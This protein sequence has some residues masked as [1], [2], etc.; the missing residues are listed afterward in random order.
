MDDEWPALGA[1]APRATHIRFTAND[2]DSASAP[3]PMDHD[4]PRFRDARGGARSGARGDRGVVFRHASPEEA[5]RRGVFSRR[6]HPSPPPPHQEPPPLAPSQPSAPPPRRDSYRVM[7]YN[8]LAAS[9]SRNHPELYRGVPD[10]W[11]GWPRRLRGVLAEVRALRPDVLCLQECEDFEGVRRGLAADGYEGAHAPRS[12]DKADGSSV[13]WRAEAFACE[14]TETID[15]E[16]RGLKNNAAAIARLRPRADP[17]APALVV[18]CVH[19]LFNPKRGDVK[20][21]QLRVF[22]ERA[23]AMRSGDP[24]DPSRAEVLLAG[25][26]NAEP[27]SPLYHFALTGELDV[28][29]V[30]RKAMS[31]CL[32]LASDD[33]AASIAE[34]HLMM[35]TGGFD[36]DDDEWAEWEENRRIAR[37]SSARGGGGGGGGGGVAG[38]VR[39]A[40]TRLREYFW[41]DEAIFAAFG[42]RVPGSAAAAEG[43]G[44]APARSVASRGCRVEHALRGELASCYRG[45]LGREPAATS[46]HGAFRGTVDYL[47]HTRGVRPT[48]V[49][50][51][52]ERGGGE[53]GGRGLPAEEFPSDHFS[54]VADVALR[55]A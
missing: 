43:G 33:A 4:R 6:W 49:L 3:A 42:T 12:G 27:D 15:F 55:S 17:R 38:G 5:A 21:G 48:R 16:T 36:R 25:D 22:A 44:A 52:P 19:V 30:D 26:F 45:V 31:G 40:A 1:D 8:V 9:H 41:D 47:F 18:G 35:E 53:G 20:L 34:W 32:N 39:D 7:S 29:R 51:P 11:L 46:H 37:D 14:A 10:A 13:F 28:S 23:E 24:R 50:L 2:A 54:V